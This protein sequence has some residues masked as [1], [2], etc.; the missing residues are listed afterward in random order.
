MP[1]SVDSGLIGKVSNILTIQKC[2][3]PSICLGELERCSVPICQSPSEYTFREEYPMK[4]TLLHRCPARDSRLPGRY[5]PE[6]LSLED[7][8]PLG[9]TILGPVLGASLLGTGLTI[10]NANSIGFD[11]GLAEASPGIPGPTHPRPFATAQAASAEARFAVAPTP[12]SPSE[13]STGVQG[14]DSALTFGEPG[15]R[16]PQ[17]GL[18]GSPLDWA[19]QS[20][21]ATAG[22]QALFSGSGQSGLGSP[23]Q[24]PTG[25]PGL[26]LNQ[27]MA[28]VQV[29][30]AVA[31][32]PMLGAVSA[33]ASPG[34]RESAIPRL[35]VQAVTPPNYV[36]TDTAL[37]PLVPDAL[38]TVRCD[39]TPPDKFHGA[40]FADG[41]N[42]LF[43][44]RDGSLALFTSNGSSGIWLR[45]A[46]DFRTLVDKK[47]PFQHVTVDL[48]S[49]PPDQYPIHQIG[50]V[51][52]AVWIEGVWADGKGALYGVY[53]DENDQPC[54]ET[55]H[56]LRG[57][58]RVGMAKSL[59]EGLHWT[60]LGIVLKGVDGVGPRCDSQ[61]TD[62]VGGEGD[63]TLYVDTRNTPNTVYIFFSSYGWDDRPGV[64][65][66]WRGPDAAGGH[67]PPRGDVSE[68]V[69]GQMGRCRCG[70]GGPSHPHLPRSPRDASHCPETAPA[71]ALRG[72]QRF[73]LGAARVLRRQR[74]PVRDASQPGLGPH[75]R[76]R[77]I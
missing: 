14:S 25:A 28:A 5:R 31:V 26:G 70:A 69:P 19:T 18:G 12:T 63:V 64:P 33:G 34:Q 15:A 1:L 50:Y 23:S 3:G 32:R 67:R 40:C 59:D 47:T 11:A 61:S 38:G 76:M 20:A 72:N 17:G 42:P 22:V 71:R 35:G 21:L 30:G 58:Y 66:R 53:H 37:I 56:N 39:G 68:M 2:Q 43:Y 65:G 44:R 27:P 57:R 24:G 45:T 29:E 41:L 77:S 8:L 51:D 52:P 49:R 10:A 55:Y 6:L 73:R 60:D 13:E 75:R 7:R 16:V 46:A 48:S 9:D 4:S 36:I 74:R 62:T 54:F